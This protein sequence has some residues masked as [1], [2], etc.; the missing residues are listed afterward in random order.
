MWE[1]RFSMVDIWKKQALKQMFA[2]GLTSF[3]FH[4]YVLIG[5]HQIGYFQ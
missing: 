3:P 5:R 2:F 4:A 1:K